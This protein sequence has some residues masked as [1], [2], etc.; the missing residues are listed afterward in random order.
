MRMAPLV[1]PFAASASFG[2]LAG[3]AVVLLPVNGTAVEEL[4]GLDAVRARRFHPAIRRDHRRD[5]A[6]ASA[7][8][9]GYLPS[10]IR[11]AGA[12]GADQQECGGA[13]PAR[14]LA[15]HA[16]G[17]GAAVPRSRY[18]RHAQGHQIVTMQ[19]SCGAIRPA[20]H[21]SRHLISPCS[22]ALR[23]ASLSRRPPTPTTSARRSSP[24]PT[25]YSASRRTCSRLSN[26]TFSTRSRAISCPL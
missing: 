9:P 11:R 1:T 7:I 18:T 3:R 19:R 4:T 24:R 15:R 5:R 8:C 21:G 22:A 10:H 25:Q 23:S 26:R 17:A 14:L 12:R 6:P 20:H 2:K 16:A 13:A